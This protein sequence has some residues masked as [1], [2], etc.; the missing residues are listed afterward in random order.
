MEPSIGL[1][2]KQ[3]HDALEKRSNNELR[4]H[5]LTLSQLTVLLMLSD[6][7]DGTAS[8]KALEKSLRVAQSTTAGI[9]AR[10]EQKGFVVS[11]G[12]A[13]DR[14]VKRVRITEKG[15][16]CNQDARENMA[17]TEETLLAGLRDA[18]RET[19]LDLLERVNRNIQS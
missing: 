5:D 9:V 19:L 17:N 13:A 3:I 16:R 4:G 7:P 15:R 8:L 11:L 1:L 2:V 6:Q 18:E 10:L 14:R 12:D